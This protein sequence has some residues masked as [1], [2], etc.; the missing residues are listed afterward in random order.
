MEVARTPSN[1]GSPF[2]SL[3]PPLSSCSLFPLCG[4]TMEGLF[5]HWSVGHWALGPSGVTPQDSVLLEVGL[6]PWALARNNSAASDLLEGS[7]PA[8]GR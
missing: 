7:L 1:I 3:L 5:W 4:Q 6:E 8:E 2:Q